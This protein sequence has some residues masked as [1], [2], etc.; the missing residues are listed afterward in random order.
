MR[1]LVNS[2]ERRTVAPEVQ[3]RRHRHEVHVGGVVGVQRADIAPVRLPAGLRIHER[4]G[5]G[6][7]A[8][9]EAGNDVAAEVMLR[10]RG[11]GVLV[12]LLEQEAR[13]EHVNAHRAQR[14]V[15]APRHGRR[16]GRLLDE[17]TDAQVLVDPHHAKTDGVLQRHLETAHRDIRP[18]CHVRRQHGAVIHLVDVVAGQ[19]Q[20]VLGV[21]RRDDVEV[22][23]HGIRRAGVP[24]GLQALLGRQQFHELAELSAQMP[25][26]A[27]DVQDQR[28][29]LVL[30][31]N[32]D[33]PDAGIHAVG[34]RKIDDAVL[35]AERHGGLGAPQRELLQPAAAPAGQHQG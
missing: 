33:A 20:H 28:V 25:P 19:D 3:L 13:V 2:S 9:D 17:G 1:T 29:R 34:K 8:L 6:A 27:L 31:Q 23:P 26:A 14:H 35:A 21:V 16:L 7:V 32:A 11:V 30:R 18:A 5:K 24:G 15:A 12:Q 22:L 4:I 10:T